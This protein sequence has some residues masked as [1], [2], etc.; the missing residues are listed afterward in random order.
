MTPQ[1]RNAGLALALF[2]VLAMLVIIPLIDNKAATFMAAIVLMS[3]TFMATL[4][5]L[6][7]T[8]ESTR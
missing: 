6:A 3:A 7:D 8:E 5:M 2:M 1:Q 4:L